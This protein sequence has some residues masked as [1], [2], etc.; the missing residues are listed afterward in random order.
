M[1]AIAGW[2]SSPPYFKPVVKTGEAIV[3]TG[4][5]VRYKAEHMPS[6]GLTEREIDGYQAR[7]QEAREQSE[8]A[9]AE[10]QERLIK[11]DKEPTKE[12]VEDYLNSING[13]SGGAPPVNAEPHPGVLSIPP[14]FTNPPPGYQPQIII[15][16]LDSY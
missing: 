7:Q 4:N 8:K 9:Q 2:N 13:S 12:E 15:E 5:W 10:E 1:L 6:L 11:G 16:P 3:E 14:G